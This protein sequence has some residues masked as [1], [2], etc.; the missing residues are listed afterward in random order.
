M[1]RARRS[2]A[3]WH[4]PDR[5]WTRINQILERHEP[6]KLEGT[7]G[8]PRIDRRRILDGIIFQ[9]RTGCPW[10]RIPPIYGSDAT[11]HRYFRSW[12][13]SGT[14]EMIWRVLVEE[15]PDLAQFWPPPGG[16]ALKG[17]GS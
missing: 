14:F 6:E 8:R 13:D 1:G 15:S 10:N 5:L 12:S 16:S 7:R 17:D 2:P 11:M 4:V 3:L 9:L